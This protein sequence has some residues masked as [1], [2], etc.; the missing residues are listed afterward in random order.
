M[1][2]CSDCSNFDFNCVI[3]LKNIMR[4]VKPALISFVKENENRWHSRNNLMF[5]ESLKN[6]SF[7]SFLRVKFE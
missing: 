1:T 5:F 3:D 7:L 4:T 6:A 2:C